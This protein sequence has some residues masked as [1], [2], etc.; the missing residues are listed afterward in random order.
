MAKNS[1][2]NYWALILDKISMVFLKLIL[3]VDMRLSQAKHKTNNDTIVLNSMAL[4]IVIEDLYKF[5]PI[6]G[7]SLYTNSVISKKIYSKDI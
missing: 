1:C 6:V 4:I 5:F 7:K 3:I 2:Q